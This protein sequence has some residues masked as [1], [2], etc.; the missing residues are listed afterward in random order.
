[1][2]QIRKVL[3]KQTGSESRFVATRVSIYVRC[4]LCVDDA[5]MRRLSS[6]SARYFGQGITSAIRH[7]KISRNLVVNRC[8]VRCRAMTQHD[9]DNRQRT[10]TTDDDQNRSTSSWRS[11]AS[12][13]SSNCVTSSHS[14]RATYVSLSLSLCLCF[15]CRKSVFVTTCLCLRSC[16]AYPCLLP[17]NR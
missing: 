5:I 16:F 1:M 8:N 2:D 13:L 7:R 3:R 15:L 4:C 10:I 12:A 9:D 6:H 14:P 11:G 17:G